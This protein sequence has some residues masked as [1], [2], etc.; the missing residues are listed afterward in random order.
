[1]QLDACALVVPWSPLKYPVLRPSFE[2]ASL[3]WRP[4]P[5]GTPKPPQSLGHSRCLHDNNIVTIADTNQYMLDE[6]KLLLTEEERDH[7]YSLSWSVRTPSPRVPISA[8]LC[9]S[10][11]LAWAGKSMWLPSLTMRHCDGGLGCGVV[12]G[13]GWGGFKRPRPHRNSLLVRIGEHVPFF[14]LP[15]SWQGIEVFLHWV[16]EMLLEIASLDDRQWKPPEIFCR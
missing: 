7:M 8:T 15:S 2:F 16:E 4:Q 12:R 11:K 13:V 10:V 9:D 14:Q 5:S 6:V 3:S 1:M